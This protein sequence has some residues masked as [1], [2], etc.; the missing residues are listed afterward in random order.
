MSTDIV[1]WNSPQS[2]ERTYHSSAL[3]VYF[4]I[5][6]PFM[7]VTFVVWYVFHYHEKRKDRQRREKTE[8]EQNQA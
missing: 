1:H 7:L 4:A 6:L 8:R 2:E 5:S 3:R